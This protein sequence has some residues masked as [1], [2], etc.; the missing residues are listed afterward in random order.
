MF[1]ELREHTRTQQIEINNNRERI[2]SLHIG[3]NDLRDESREAT[4]VA[5]AL[6]N[7]R[8]PYE[9]DRAFSIRIGHF[10]G[11][12]AI[13]AQGA[14][15]VSKEPDVVIDLGIGQGAK[16]SQTGVSAGITWA[17]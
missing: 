1:N 10:M 8:I 13:A 15:R 9:K 11:E 17:W 2:H 12:N 14:F 3:L 6:G 7:L 16:Y 4:A 5:I